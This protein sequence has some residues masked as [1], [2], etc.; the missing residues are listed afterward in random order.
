MD[1]FQT[2]PIIGQPVLVHPE[3]GNDP[4]QR[5]GQIGIIA[6]VNLERDDIFVSFGTGPLALYGADALLTLKRPKEVY[7]Q[8]I[9]Q[10][11]SLSAAEFKALFQVSLLLDYGNDRSTRAALELAAA[12]PAVRELAMVSLEKS[13]GLQP[14]HE[15]EQ[16][17]QIRFSHR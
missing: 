2:N 16:Q 3:L 6:S 5:Q 17:T 4:A 13:L 14:R 7:L 10:A 15:S 11:K 9:S 1:N 12:S 8:V